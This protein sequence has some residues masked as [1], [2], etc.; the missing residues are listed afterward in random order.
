MLGARR[1]PSNALAAANAG[2]GA[3]ASGLARSVR[4]ARCWFA[5]ALAP[6]ACALAL[7]AA[8]TASEPIAVPKLTAHA[9][10]LTGTLSA[11]EREALDGKLAAFEAAKGSQVAV[12]IVPSIGTETIEEFAG[13]VTDEWKLGRKAV[14]DGVLLVIAKQ[15][16]KIR[17]QTGRGV[18]GTLTDALSRRI[19]ADIV[20][21]HFRS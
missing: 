18:Q 14:D 10:D 13:R 19:A 21:P 1:A 4:R 2:A 8:P 5:A 12:L 3:S 17:I 11:P 20:A 15:E 6:C 16:R 9:V 7:A